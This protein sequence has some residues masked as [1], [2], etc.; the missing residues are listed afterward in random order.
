ME[1]LHH[2]PYWLNTV[3]CS[4]KDVAKSQYLMSQ[5]SEL[6]V[7]VVVFWTLFLPA[8]KCAS[9]LP[10]IWLVGWIFHLL[11]IPQSSI[12][13]HLG[14]PLAIGHVRCLKI[15][16]RKAVNT[17]SDS[18]YRLRYGGK[19]LCNAIK[20]KPHLEPLFFAR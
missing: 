7:G 11:V 19:F 17:E 8:A 3:L 6:S 2:S 1:L 12:H 10:P 15:R 4:Y 18:E 5:L 16:R 20:C 14:S 13:Q 9:S